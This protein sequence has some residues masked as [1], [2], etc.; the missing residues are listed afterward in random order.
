M[1][2][3]S[4]LKKLLHYNPK[5]GVFTRIISTNR[6]VKIGDVAG[7]KDRRG[8]IAVWIMG[9]SCMAHRLAWLYM[10]G[11]WPKNEIDHE[12]H[13]RD[14]NRIINLREATRLEN[15]KNA[16]KRK[17]NTSGVCG[18]H[19]SER[20]KRW[21]AQVSVKGKR[22]FLGCFKDKFGAMCARKSADNKYGFH[23][24]HGA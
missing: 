18:I 4:E 16:S 20:D 3:Q 7:S 13:V 12:N 23:E 10:S 9:K 11:S 22:M 24:N 1:I 14:D 2:T 19:W 15:N 17:D 5:T 6:S 8:Y 21:Y